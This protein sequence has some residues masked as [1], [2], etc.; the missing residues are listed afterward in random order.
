M[1]LDSGFAA[2]TTRDASVLLVHRVRGCGRVLGLLGNL[3][4][5]VYECSF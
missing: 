5:D 2:S 1:V 3:V 4:G